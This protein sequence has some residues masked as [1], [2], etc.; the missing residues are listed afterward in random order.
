MDWVSIAKFQQFDIIELQDH[1]PS[2]KKLYQITQKFGTRGEPFNAYNI[3][4]DREEIIF[5]GC[6]AI[7]P[8]KNQL[9]RCL[10]HSLPGVRDAA[11]HQ[12]LKFKFRTD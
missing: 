2:E 7:F 4:D 10:T 11:E 8:T 3:S 1:N 5:R 6:S 9:Y 12:L